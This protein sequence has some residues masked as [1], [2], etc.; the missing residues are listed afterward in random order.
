M[1]IFI[2]DTRLDD[3]PDAPTAI[4]L[5][6]EHIDGADRLIIDINADGEPAPDAI[7]DGTDDGASIAELRFTTADTGAF[8]SETV[9]AAKESLDLIRKD[10]TTAAEQIRAGEM[11]DAM[12]AL[13][14]IMEGWQGVRDVVDQVAQLAGADAATLEAHSEAHSETGS[15]GGAESGQAII[16]DLG[17]ALTEIRDTLAQEDWASLGDVVEYDLA[18]LADRWDALLDALIERAA[19]R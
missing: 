6:R 15:E 19:R 9:H 11:E 13:R 8:L 4:A 3:A 17:A 7:L 18:T 10:Q 5:A 12:H 1:R 16:A 14:A 2:D